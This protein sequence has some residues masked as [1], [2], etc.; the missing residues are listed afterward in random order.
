MRQQARTSSCE[1]RPPGDFCQGLRVTS[2][3][4]QDPHISESRRY[5]EARTRRICSAEVDG[6][7]APSSDIL[8]LSGTLARLESTID[9]CTSEWADYNSRQR[10]LDFERGTFCLRGGARGLRQ[11]YMTTSTNFSASVWLCRTEPCPTLDDVEP[12]SCQACVA[13]GRTPRYQPHIRC[14]THGLGPIGYRRLMVH[15]PP[16][17]PGPPKIDDLRPAPQPL[18]QNPCVWPPKHT[19]S[20]CRIRTARAGRLGVGR[21]PFAA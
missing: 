7:M 14:L 4:V 11:P 3:T 1:L 18:M 6:R 8:D 15:R 20:R 19:A 5:I 17:P 9:P 16:G 13:V 12:L 21:G 10:Q 2:T